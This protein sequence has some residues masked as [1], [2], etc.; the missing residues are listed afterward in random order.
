MRNGVFQVLGLVARDGGLAP[1]LWRQAVDGG[2]IDVEPLVFEDV[3]G[4]LGI[5]AGPQLSD[6]TMLVAYTRAT[7]DWPEVGR[8]FMRTI[9]DRRDAG[10]DCARDSDCG[11]NRCVQQRCCAEGEAC[12]PAATPT[13]PRVYQVCGCGLGDSTWWSVALAVL[14]LRARKR[15]HRQRRQGR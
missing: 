14:V 9:G 4:V 12:D 8:V 15:S 6:G 11:S 1:W 13:G 3:L 2:V 10:S 5:A 7:A